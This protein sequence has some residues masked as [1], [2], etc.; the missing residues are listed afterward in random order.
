MPLSADTLIHFTEKKDFL[1][2]ILEGDFRIFYC[3]ETIYFDQSPAIIYVPMV[4]FCDIPL[5]QIKEH[6]FKYGN[7][8]IGMT[9]KWAYEQK[10]NP[11]LYVARNSS[12]ASSYIGA[13]KRFFSN[14]ATWNLNVNEG[15]IELID[16]IRYIKNYEA[17]LIRKGKITPNYR[18][19]DEREWRYAPPFSDDYEFF[20]GDKVFLRNGGKAVFNEKISKLRL[21]FTPDDIRYII[22]EKESEI[23]EFIEHLH[24]VKGTNY[25]SKDI[26]RLTTRILT[27]EQINTDF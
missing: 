2:K 20:L 17:D 25:S 11:V 19:S 14:D 9:K 13:I 7:Y 6:M 21:K 23:D 1:K 10:M 8:G 22:I 27:S 12:L 4:S 24:Q 3:E 18:F 16:V 5:S 26:K 15:H